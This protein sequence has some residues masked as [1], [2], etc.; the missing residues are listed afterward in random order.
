MLLSDPVG[1]T[2][3]D[4]VRRAPNLT[5]RAGAW[6]AAVA[7]RVTVPVLLVSG[8]HDKQVDPQR[9]RQLHAAFGSADKV[10]IDLGCSSHNAMW[11]RNHLL[12]FD[13]SRQWLT[14]GSVNGTKNGALR[15]GY[16][17]TS[18]PRTN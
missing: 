10:F 12:L 11:E 8:V 13:A 6:D 14:T 17:G 18:E 4:G 2:W 7:A 9:V 16:P 3:G 15:L 1:A 5:P